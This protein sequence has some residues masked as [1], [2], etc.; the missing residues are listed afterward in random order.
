MSSLRVSIP[1]VSNSV[2]LFLGRGCSNLLASF[3]SIRMAGPASILT[4]VDI[5]YVS[6]RRYPEDTEAIFQCMA[7]VGE[8]HPEIVCGYLD[9][10]LRA[11]WSLSLPSPLP[12]LVDLVGKLFRIDSRFLPQEIAL[13]D[14]Q[15]VSNVFLLFGACRVYPAKIATIPAYLRNHYEFISLRYPDLAPRIHDKEVPM[16]TDIEQQADSSTFVETVLAKFHL[17]SL[18][19]SKGSSLA[20]LLRN[21]HGI[22]FDL[23][24]LAADEPSSRDACEL[25]ASHIKLCV[26]I[27]KMREAFL[28]EMHENVQHEA[29]V[30][31]YSTYRIEQTFSLLSPEYG[32]VLRCVRALAHLFWAFG[33]IASR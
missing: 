18:G 20:I 32:H 15:H 5:L 10:Q 33:T 27:L 24:T 6:L 8:H 19:I 3:R 25:L 17:A 29:C 12:L 4:F 13:Q 1:W 21:L 28:A 22:T 9:M 23:E 7:K 16:D 11:L 31:L 2:V 14:L 30:L 26:G